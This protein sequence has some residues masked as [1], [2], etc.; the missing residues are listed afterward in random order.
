MPHLVATRNRLICLF[1]QTVCMLMAWSLRKPMVDS[2]SSTRARAGVR[3]EGPVGEGI[4][5]AQKRVSCGRIVP[6]TQ[7]R[8]DISSGCVVSDST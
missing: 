1:P 7:A 8:R 2:N 5:A 4:D 6:G 3:L